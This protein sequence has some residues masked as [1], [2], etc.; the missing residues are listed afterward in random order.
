MSA[1]NRGLQP[2]PDEFYRTPEW[3]VRPILEEL[4]PKTCMYSTYN[5][6]EPACGDGA[7]VE[8][9]RTIQRPYKIE[10]DAYDINP[11]GCGLAGGF[12]TMPTDKKY[13]LI[14]TNP[15]FSLALEFAKKAMTLR[16][17][18]TSLAVLLVRLGFL[19]GQLRADWMRKH[20]PSIYISPKR[21][22]FRLNKKGKKGSD[23]TDYCWAVWGEHRPLVNILK[24]EDL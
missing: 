24:T 13:D 10:I 16:K 7:I 11:R 18:I 22:M 4:I 1:K 2:L 6:L 12:L 8:V 9:M 15:P 23:A 19:A 21:P 3:L 5:I 14:L 17:D 20:T